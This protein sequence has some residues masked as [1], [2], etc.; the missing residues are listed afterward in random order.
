MA[1]DKVMTWG[2]VLLLKHA[3]DGVYIAYEVHVD[4]NKDETIT[5]G[6]SI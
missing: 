4:G 6:K 1:Q 3:S 2:A 5:L